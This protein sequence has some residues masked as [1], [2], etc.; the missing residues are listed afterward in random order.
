M[1]PISF[2]FLCSGLLL[3]SVPAAA[4]QTD[5]MPEEQAA[6]DDEARQLFAA[7]ETAYSNGRYDS[8]LE[9]FTRAYDLSHRPMLLYNVG[10]SAEL[11][12]HDERAVA[13]YRQFLTEVPDSPQQTRVQ[14]R[15]REL[16]AR[17]AAAALAVQ[18]PQ[19]DRVTD[20]VP[21]ASEPP[22]ASS[23]G[24]GTAG[25]VILGAGAAL[26][27]TGAVLVGVAASDASTVEN[28]PMGSSWSSVEGAASRAEPMSIAGIAL[29]TVGIVGVGVGL[30]IALTA[31]GHDEPEVA[32]RVGPGSLA[33]TGRF[34]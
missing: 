34:Q 31:G 25:W 21:V 29:L 10:L 30:A 6:L 32:L 1:R 33:L 9:Y 11:A 2:L 17:L 18:P 20:D 23:G 5:A 8:A 16:E 12:R 7:G 24:D 26:A 13:A 3:A 28:A 19:P 27:I 4:Q 14:T 22:R 15:V